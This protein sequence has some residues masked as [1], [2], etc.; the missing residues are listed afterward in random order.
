MPYCVSGET[1]LCLL[2]DQRV[3]IVVCEPYAEDGVKTVF[4]RTVDDL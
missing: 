4:K 1:R 2:K 3:L